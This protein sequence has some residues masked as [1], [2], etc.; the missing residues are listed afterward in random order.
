MRI[1]RI[2]ITA[3]GRLQDETIVLQ[4]AL[5]VVL[6]ANEAG[7]TT[8]LRA[9]RA[10]LYGIDAGGQ[11]RAL[12]RSDWSRWRPWDRQERYGLAMT[13]TLQD[14]RRFRV[15]RRL[16]LHREEVQ[17][18]EV[19]GRVVTDSMRVGRLVV[20][21]WHHLGIDEAVFCATACL[22]E[23]SLRT[24]SPDT[25][26]ARTDRLQEAIERLADSAS[27]ATAAEAL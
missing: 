25:A 3:F 6:G 8:L 2:D 7:K 12:A 1:E 22:G 13:Y 26:A 27:R 20:P 18:V 21:G 24:D 15:A 19:G 23:E 10:V 5:T 4:P 11:G 14:E 16:E 17:V 9:V